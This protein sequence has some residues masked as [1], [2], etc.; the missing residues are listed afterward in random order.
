MRLFSAAL[1]IGILSTAFVSVAPKPVDAAYCMFCRSNNT[2]GA[3]WWASAAQCVFD[4][5]QCEEWGVCF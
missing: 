2:C 4:N 3:N 1:L 5:G